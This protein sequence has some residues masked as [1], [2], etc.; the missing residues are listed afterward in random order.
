MFFIGCLL[1]AGCHRRIVHCF[2]IGGWKPSLAENKESD[3]EH[4]SWWSLVLMSWVMLRVKYLK[5]LQKT[6]TISILLKSQLDG[7]TL[8]FAQTFMDATGMNLNRLW[9]SSNFTSSAITRSE[10]E[11]LQYF[12]SGTINWLTKTKGYEVYSG[13]ELILHPSFMETTS[14]TYLLGRG[15]NDIPISLSCTL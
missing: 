15:N 10:F 14:Q 6:N 12:N 1:R 2:H 9:W 8:H 4:D 7:L 3:S 11:C 5:E 13:L